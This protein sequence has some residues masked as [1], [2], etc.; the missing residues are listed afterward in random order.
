MMQKLALLAIA[1]ALGTLARYS[2][3]G[4]VHRI[5]GTTFPLGTMIVNLT[6]CFLAGLLW[7]LFETRWPVTGETR[8]VVLVGFMGAFTTFSAFIL[9]T[10]ELIR[11]AEWLHAV[12]NVAMQNTL[13]IVALF[14]G[15]AIGYMS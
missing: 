3:S 10:G 14:T 12:A 5:S 13:G 1:G 4:L 8:M 7:A 15:A 11:S 2:L 6:G 9:E